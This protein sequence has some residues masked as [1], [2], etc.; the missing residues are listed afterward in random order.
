MTPPNRIIGAVAATVALAMAL[1]SAAG[2]SKP[3]DRTFQQTFPVASALCAK[4]AAG[5][6]GPRLKAKL[7]QVTADCAALEAA[8]APAHTTVLAVRTALLPTLIAD[9]TA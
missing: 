6:E 7:A 5:T 9:R 2:A 3:G 1:P 8:F 4:V